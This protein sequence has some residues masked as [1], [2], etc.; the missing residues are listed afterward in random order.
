MLL[1]FGTRPEA[2]KMMPLIKQGKLRGSEVEVR[3][4]LSAQHREMLDE[5]LELFDVE[6][7]HD[8]DLMRAG[9]TPTEVTRRMLEK[10]P[11]VYRTERPDVV[12]VQGDTTTTFA[13]AY[14][15]F[16]EHIPVAHVEAGLRTGDL[17]APFPEEANRKLTSSITTFHFP[18]TELS[19]RNLLAEGYDPQSIWVTGNTVIDTLLDVVERTDLP[20]PEIPGGINGR[21]ILVTAH[22]R[23]SFGEPIRGVFNALK[24]LAAR[25]AD[26]T[27]VYPVHPNP[28]IKVPAEEILSGL[29][30]VRLIAPVG[31]T[32]L[33]CLMRRA[34]LV[35]T[36]SGGIQ[37][38]APSLGVPVLVLRETTERPE[39]VYAG[40][41][42]LVGTDPQKILDQAGIL[43]TDSEAHAA[44]A[45]AANPYGDGHAA[46][47]IIDVLTRWYSRT[48]G[49]K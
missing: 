20:E 3:V 30:N 5:V 14:A 13:A 24:Q 21:L 34:A 27:L 31:Y 32:S 4:A 38:E 19:K 46:E 7:H 43:L 37:E 39:G 12:V 42:K 33:V 10:L 2:I 40:T 49:G 36:D 22:R 47:R 8:L 11:E 23:E 29:P 41:V 45:K 6:P 16:L 28:N 26:D 44:M 18:P 48:S 17:T 15:A 35:L 1:V 25:F 9:Q